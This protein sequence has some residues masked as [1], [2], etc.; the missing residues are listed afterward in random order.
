VLASC[1]LEVYPMLNPVVDAYSIGVS[2]AV[3]TIPNNTST[4]FRYYSILYRIYISDIVL[5]GITSD[6]QRNTINPALASHYNTINPYTTRTNVTPNAIGTV[7]S[8][9]HYYPLYVS[10]DKSREIAMYQ[11]LSNHQTLSGSYPTTNIHNLNAGDTVYLDFT[12]AADGPYMTI[13]YGIPP[14]DTT[15]RLYLFRAKN[16]FT[17]IPSDRLFFK[18]TDILNESFI[19]TSTNADVEPKSNLILAN[20]KQAYVSMYI[21]SIGYDGNYSPVYSSAKHI[22]IFHLPTP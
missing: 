22:G 11:L 12:D 10:V 4:E 7:F 17:P 2:S 9:L 8:N 18:S 16:N 3:I 5:T 19:T 20:P 14:P 15:G 6:S 1:G 21:L 13:R